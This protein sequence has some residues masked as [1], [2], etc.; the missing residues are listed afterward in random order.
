MRVLHLFG[1]W[2][3]TGPAEP[4][5]DL[6]VELR[7]LG[8][9]VTLACR[10]A[11]PEAAQSLPAR[12]RARGIEPSFGFALNK[13]LNLSDNLA[14][15]RKLREACEGGVFDLVHVHF[16]HDHIVGAMGARG[17]GA[18]VVRTNHKGT[19]L[20]W[21]LCR[22]TDGYLTF[23]AA[24]PTVARLGRP[25]RVIA[26]ALDLGR[27]DPGRSGAGVRARYGLPD[28]AFV[29]GVVAR[30][31][32]HRRFDVFLKGVKRALQRVPDLRV[33]V[34]GRGTHREK[35]AVEPARRMGLDSVVTFT[36]YVGEGYP[37]VLAAFDALV[38]L[39]PGSD[40]TCR[41]LREAMAM[42]K[43]VI[44]ARRGMIPELVDDGRT[45]LVVDDTPE[46]IADAIARLAGDRARCRAMGRAG[47]EKAAA[48]YDLGRQAREVAGLYDEVLRL[49]REA[50]ARA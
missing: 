17:A 31:Q 15:I 24:D 41:A 38:F 22:L 50:A 42:G 10:P 7:A 16:S 27:F 39:V 30:V 23:S 20:P 43:A 45:G 33:L 36:G 1:D 21:L 9:D 44:G 29:V 19:A 13:K 34:V 6:V 11:P 5:L 49:R 3:W 18:P 28:D 35:V 4:T 12:A 26:P 2:K 8:L 40:G 37:D 32:K 47:R 48:T 46:G 25:A 14:D